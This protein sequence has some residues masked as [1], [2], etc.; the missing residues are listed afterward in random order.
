MTSEKPSTRSKKPALLSGLSAYEFTKKFTG[1]SRKPRE[2]KT[3]QDSASSFKD[4]S[5]SGESSFLS[6]EEGEQPQSTSKLNVTERSCEEDLL[7]Q[8]DLGSIEGEEETFESAGASDASGSQQ[9]INEVGKTNS[10]VGEEQNQEVDQ[11]DDQSGSSVNSTNSSQEDPQ[12]EE[13]EKE[14]RKQIPTPP[15]RPPTPLPQ[16]TRPYYR[17][18]RKST[19][20]LPPPF[21]NLEFPTVK[22]PTASLGKFILPITSKMT[23]KMPKYTQPLTPG[24]IG[25]F[26]GTFE[27]WATKAKQND[28]AKKISFTTAVQNELAQQWFL[29]NKTVIL[30]VTTTWEEFRDNFLKE[31]AMEGDQGRQGILEILGQKQGPKEKASWFVQ[32]VRYQ[33]GEEWGTF[34]EKDIIISLTRQLDY[35]LRRY[36]ECRGIPKTYTDFVQM[37]RDYEANGIREKEVTEVKVKQE[38]VSV[39]MAAPTGPGAFE[40][41]L[42]KDS[43][44]NKIDELTKFIADINIVHNQPR[45]NQKPAQTQRR[46]D[47]TPK[48]NGICYFCGKPGHFKSECKSFARRGA[49]SSNYRGGQNQGQ[50]FQTPNFQYRQPQPQYQQHFN[51]NQAMQPASQLWYP[52]QNAQNMN[53][54]N[55]QHRAQ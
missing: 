10:G 29:I 8:I 6:R 31:C 52:P 50:N 33:I 41:Q 55:G 48:R 28:A 13:I 15:P 40:L 3:S 47:G 1:Y 26:I 51:S 25:L 16:F 22:F 11:S 7:L 23:D 42:F 34:K 35:E 20:L 45:E 38:K 9:S 24:A 5:I 54:G 2:E 17:L 43:V 37:V 32:K 14:N 36:I 21:P 53:Q 30:D 44:E 12:E 27:L 39:N 18:K 4:L 49:Q 46:Q 19:I